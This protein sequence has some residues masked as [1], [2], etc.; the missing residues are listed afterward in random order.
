MIYHIISDDVFFLSG[1][2]EVLKKV[3]NEASIMSNN[4]N[5]NGWRYTRM[6]ISKIPSQKIIIYINCF[7]KRRIVLRLA[8]AH[9][10]VAIIIT[11]FRTISN[12][13]KNNPM[14]ISAQCSREDLLFSI[15]NSNPKYSHKNGSKSSQNIIRRLSSGVSI[16]ELATKLGM[17]QKMIYTIKNNAIRKLG[18]TTT[19][20]HG[21]LLCRDILEMNRIN[22]CCNNIR[23]GR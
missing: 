10:L 17:S 9:N 16:P 13:V 8:A 6:A 20:L 3:I 7:R 1:A 22:L 2:S 12:D 14:L 4:I 21:L 5:V 19:K 15:L 11:P 18:L 23:N